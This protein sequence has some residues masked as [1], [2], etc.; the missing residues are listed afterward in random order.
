MYDLGLQKKIYSLKIDKNSFECIDSLLYPIIKEIFRKYHFVTIRVE[1][2]DRKIGLPRLVRVDKYHYSSEFKKFKKDLERILGTT[3]NIKLIIHGT[4]Y[5]IYG[6]ILHDYIGYSVFGDPVGILRYG[7]LH[8]KIKLKDKILEFIQEDKLYE[9]LNNKVKIIKNKNKIQEIKEK[10]Y[11]TLDDLIQNYKKVLNTLKIDPKKYHIY[12]LVFEN[13]KISF[14]NIVEVENKKFGKTKHKSEELVIKYDDLMKDYEGIL[15]KIYKTK[16]K[17][18]ILVGGRIGELSH[19][20]IILRELN[21][22]L[23][24]VG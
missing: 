11:L 3:P 1:T 10:I 18:V 9:Y 13:M 6:G 16:P 19:F 22:K 14:F 2:T 7:D 12:Y 20:A 24:Q 21:I 4:S 23:I 17:K 5:P 15:L 8:F